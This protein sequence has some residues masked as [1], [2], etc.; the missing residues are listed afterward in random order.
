MKFTKR[1]GVR[2]APLISFPEI[3]ERFGLSLNQLRSDF[4]NS[5]VP[6]PPVALHHTGFATSLASRAKWYRLK[7]VVAWR[8]AVLASRE[9]PSV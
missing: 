1:D 9:P 3:A 8:E 6:S 7:D 4:S 5:K 2:R